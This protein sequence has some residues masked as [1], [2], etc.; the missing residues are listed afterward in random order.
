MF[1]TTLPFLWNAGNTL[2]LFITRSDAAIKKSMRE[3]HVELGKR[4]TE[5]EGD[6][7]G[8]VRE[9][10]AEAMRR[11]DLL[12]KDLNG[13]GKRMERMDEK[14]KTKLDRESLNTEVKQLYDLLRELTRAVAEIN[15]SQ[16]STAATVTAVERQLGL[17]NVYL[18][19][20][21]K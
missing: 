4:I 9:H 18:H 21:N 15:K 1:F 11:I 12:E 5:T 7:R 19:E 8:I 13:L 2:A 20:A 14:V 10:H 16:A 6:I 3:N 17:I